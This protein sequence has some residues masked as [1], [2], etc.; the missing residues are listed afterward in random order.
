[1]TYGKKHG[2]IWFALSGVMLTV[3]PYLVDS[4]ALSL[5][6]GAALLAAPF[7]LEPF[8][9]PDKRRLAR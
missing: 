5:S 7:V 8:F 2:R 3:Y 4:L 1:V 6:I 9:C